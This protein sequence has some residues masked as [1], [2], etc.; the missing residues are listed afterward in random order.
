MGRNSVPE[1]LSSSIHVFGS[2]QREHLVHCYEQRRNAAF[3]ESATPI[4]RTGHLPTRALSGRPI[5]RCASIYTVDKP[6]ARLTYYH[7]SLQ[8]RLC[9]TIDPNSFIVSLP[10]TGFSETGPVGGL[11][12]W[13][14]KVSPKL[15]Q[16]GSFLGCF[17]AAR[18]SHASL[19]G[20]YASQS[21]G[22][23]RRRIVSARRGGI[24]ACP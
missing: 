23:G 11:D 12:I 17:H 3:G 6:D 16:R 5:V 9:G 13:L 18:R 21:A 10:V 2:A 7:C 14:L 24:L 1:W 8:Q 22:D 4:L 19:H 15:V 20:Q